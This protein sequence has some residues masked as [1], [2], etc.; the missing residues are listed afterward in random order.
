MRARIVLTTVFGELVSDAEDLSEELVQAFQGWS[1]ESFV[2]I[3]VEGRPLRIDCSSVKSLVVRK[4]ETVED[5]HA[6]EHVGE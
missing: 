6:E 1:K 4:E 3:P 5:R 2:T